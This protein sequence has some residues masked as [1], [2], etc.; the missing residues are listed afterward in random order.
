MPPGLVR[1]TGVRGPGRAAPRA[2]GAGRPAGA[3]RGWLGRP[4]GGVRGGS[5]RTALADAAVELARKRG[6]QVV[7]AVPARGQ[8]GRLIWAQLLADVGAAQAA[9]RLLE[10]GAGPLQPVGAADRL[11][12]AGD[13]PGAV[14]A[15][16]R[17]AM[18]AILRGRFEEAERLAVEVAELADVPGWPTPSGSP[19]RYAARSRPSGTRRPG[20]GG[21]RDRGPGRR[22]GVVRRA[23]AL[24]RPAGGLGWRCRRQRAGVALPRPAGGPAGAARRRRRPPAGG[25]RPAGANRGPARP[26]PQPG[27]PGRRPR[28]PRRPWRRPVGVRSAAPGPPDRGAAGDAGAAGAAGPP[29]RRVDPGPGW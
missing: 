5:G 16:A 15:T 25:G 26:G 17:H 11:A 19:G 23:W 12:A 20:R 1:Y 24:R 22:G 18:L 28:D 6:F 8:P 2:A 27:R 4:A 3:C 29:G 13:A 7:R 9:A 10:G 21:R 14:M